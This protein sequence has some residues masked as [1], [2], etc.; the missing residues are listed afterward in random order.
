MQGHDGTLSDVLP[1][2]QKSLSMF[3]S[4]SHIKLDDSNGLKCSDGHSIQRNGWEISA[5]THSISTLQKGK[6]VSSGL[7]FGWEMEN[8]FTIPA[9]ILSLDSNP[10]RFSKAQIW[11]SVL[12]SIEVPF[13][14]QIFL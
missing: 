7:W 3:F 8:L 5:A 1:V 10:H 14:A 11:L 2:L 4:W 9:E 6:P 13:P 12:E